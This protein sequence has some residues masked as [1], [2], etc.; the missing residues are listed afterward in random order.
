MI[1]LVVYLPPEKYETQTLF[2]GSIYI[3]RMYMIWLVVY[4]PPEKYE[5]QIGSSSQL[6]GRIK[7]FYIIRIYMIWLV[8]YLPL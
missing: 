8:V 7:M 3:I 5:S 6:L 4:L 1:W 2:L